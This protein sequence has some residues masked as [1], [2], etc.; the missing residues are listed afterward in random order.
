MP[1]M[2]HSVQLSPDYLTQKLKQCNSYVATRELGF[3]SLPHCDEVV[4]IRRFFQ[5]FVS[6]PTVRARLPVT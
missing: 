1:F 2:A 3:P 6:L 5:F 4:G